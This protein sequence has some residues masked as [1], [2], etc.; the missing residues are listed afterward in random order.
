MD[1]VV[2]Q[3]ATSAEESAS[4]AVEMDSQANHLKDVVGNLTNLVEVNQGSAAVTI[5]QKP[6]LSN[7]KH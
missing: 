1:K 7:E 5:A 2:Q 6:S 4:A 3:N